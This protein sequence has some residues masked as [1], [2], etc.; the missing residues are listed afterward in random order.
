MSCQSGRGSA[1][2]APEST[3]PSIT[4]GLTPAAS[5]RLDLTQMSPLFAAV[6]HAGAGRRHALGRRRRRAARRSAAQAGSKARPALIIMR[7]TMP[8]EE[9]V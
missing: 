9:S 8:G 6:E 3:R 1:I 7:N 2:S 5:A 4:P